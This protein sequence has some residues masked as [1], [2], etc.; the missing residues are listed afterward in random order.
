MKSYDVIV[1]GAG[2]AGIMSAIFAA[3]NKKSVLLL[4]KN[5]YIGRKILAT[6]NGRCNLTNRLIE[7]DRYHGAN[8]E[9]IQNILE[10][11]DQN[12][13]MSFFENLGV[14]LKEEDRGR[15]F[16]R[17]NQ[18]KTI[19][20]ALTHAIS[21]HQNIEVVTCCEV[22]D[23]QK[24]DKF[25]VQITN[26]KYFAKKVILA[27][28]GKAAFQFGSSGDGL[29]WTKKMGHNILPIYAALAPI[30]TA[31][32]WVSDISGIKIEARVTTKSNEKLIKETF[33][34]VLF[35]HFGLSGPAIMAH[36]REI[37]PLLDQNVTLS[38]DLFP[39]KSA[40]ELES[41]IINLIENNN[42]KSIK[43]VLSGILPQNLVPK[44]LEM[45][46]VNDKK[47]AELSKVERSNICRVI[48]DFEFHISKIRP[49]KE[50]QVSRG[51][52]DTKEINVQNL[53]SKIIPG[54]Y[55]AGEIIDVDA[56]SGGFN[57]QWAWASG[58]LA[59]K[60]T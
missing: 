2:P 11:F 10:S 40:T 33:G 20:E 38:L 30:E 1:I 28:G 14:I 23:I 19:V 60:S 48:K 56:D 24:N 52:V 17:T 15:I 41:L 32:K 27:T 46:N 49:L 18:A 51:G 26:E 43:N 3:K 21:D 29:F 5:E 55:F 8:P 35:T 44:I 16:P 31:E 9:F 37:A 57:L 36:S 45:A 34:D 42:K 4:E 58:F 6:G 12:Q 59:G 47:S 54:L 25:E 53:E 39:E 50:A 22:K 7:I 13:T